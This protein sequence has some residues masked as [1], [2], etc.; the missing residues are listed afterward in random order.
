MQEVWGAVERRGFSDQGLM[1]EFTH[2]PRQKDDSC[3]PDY[4]QENPSDFSTSA[5]VLT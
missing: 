2:S 3:S 4:F 1:H 5:L